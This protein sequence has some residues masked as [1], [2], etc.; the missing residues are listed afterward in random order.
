MIFLKEWSVKSFQKEWRVESEEW[1]VELN[2]NSLNSPNSK[3]QTLDVGFKV[4]KLDTSNLTL[5]DSTPTSS[6]DEV[7]QRMLSM[8]ETIKLDRTD[9]DVVYEVMLK[10]GIPLDF[11]IREIQINDKK[12][13]SIGE[14]CLVLVC[15]DYG[16]DG[17]TPE[18][19]EKMCEFLPAKIVSSEK[20]FKDDTALSNAHYILKDRDIEMK[21]L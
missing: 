9:M 1:R 2:N 18:D 19:M 12:G 4:F 5:W 3:L 8:Q 17:I 21:L 20:S 16:K 10:L 6:D 15:L 7:V 13:Y 11:P 14:N